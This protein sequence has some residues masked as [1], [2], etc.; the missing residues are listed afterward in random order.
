M[1]LVAQ[2]VMEGA[3]KGQ[4]PNPEEQALLGYSWYLRKLE[5][6]QQRIWLHT[7]GNRSALNKSYTSDGTK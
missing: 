1:W 2:V 7:S 5:T 3:L 6:G 4:I